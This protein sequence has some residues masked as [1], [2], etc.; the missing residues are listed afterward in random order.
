[1]NEGANDAS[2]N[3]SDHQP[4]EEA[5]DIVHD[6][7]GQVPTAVQSGIEQQTAAVVG[8]MSGDIDQYGYQQRRRSSSNNQMKVQNPGSGMR[9]NEGLGSLKDIDEMRFSQVEEE[10]E[11]G[12]GGF[13]TVT[14]TKGYVVDMEASNQE[15]VSHL[16]ECNLDFK[17]NII[18]QVQ[19]MKLRNTSELNIAVEELKS[20]EAKELGQLNQTYMKLDQRSKKLDRKVSTSSLTDF[21]SRTKDSNP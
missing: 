18:R 15:F 9:V 12:S 20:Q 5:H 2:M 7:Q 14:E 10:D 3:V 1:M 19:T 21:F 13:Y 11:A 8:N 16:Y 6:L 17:E 4:D